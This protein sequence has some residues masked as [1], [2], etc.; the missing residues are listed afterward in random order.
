M[1]NTISWAQHTT[2]IACK[3]AFT[4]WD[5]LLTFSCSKHALLSTNPAYYGIC[6]SSLGLCRHYIS[7]FTWKTSEESAPASQ[8]WRTYKIWHCSPCAQKKT[9]SPRSSTDTC[10]CNRCSNQE[11]TMCKSYEILHEW[12]STCDMIK[13]NQS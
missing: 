2:D 7:G 12:L 5:D 3:S 1:V 10:F 6:C 8:D 9:M 11:S 13:Q 4:S